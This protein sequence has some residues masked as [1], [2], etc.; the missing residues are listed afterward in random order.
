MSDTLERSALSLVDPELAARLTS[1]IRGEF[2]QLPE[3]YPERILEQAL[4]YLKACAGSPGSVLSPSPL[5][6]IGWHTFILH[7]REYSE[8]CDE[9]AGHFIHHVPENESNPPP[10]DPD[11]IRRRTMKAIEE[12]GYRVDP[13][14]WASLDHKCKGGGGPGGPGGGC[15]QGCHDSA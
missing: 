1:H 8:F 11:E 10:G 5:V 9:V 12:C 15:H 6:D 3:G 13:E 7:S 4:A 14:L 2:P